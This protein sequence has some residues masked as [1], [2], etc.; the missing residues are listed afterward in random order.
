MQISDFER[1]LRS[2]QKA[3]E[4]DNAIVEKRIAKMYKDAYKSAST[5]LSELYARL[6]DKMSLPEAQKYNRLPLV[7][8]SIAAEYQKL[9]GKNILLAIDTSAQN[10][11]EAFYG[12]QWAAN[13]AIGIDLTWGVL[14]VE[15]IRASV[16]SE[17]SGLTL[18]KTFKKNAA[19]E[20]SSIQAAIT[21]GIATGL[22]YAKTAE[23]MKG[24]FN[25]GFSDAI[26][27]LLT[28]AGRNYTE[29]HLKAHDEALELGIDVVKVWDAT[30]DGRTRDAHGAL[31]CQEED[32]QGNFRSS[33]GG[34]GPG[35]GLMNNAADDIN[36]R[37]RI[38]DN[39]RGMSPELRR[40]RG[41]GV[42]PYKTFKQ[43]SEP[44]GW[45]QT[46]GWPRARWL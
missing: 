1:L 45:T 7:L 31:D 34:Y 9:T 38:T 2:R 28:E 44:K 36:E 24:A 22:G 4:A 5:Q 11:T 15:A 35:P 40:I 17:Y 39:I 10:Y 21:R 25:K 37:C 6:G 8:K 19:Q 18:I 46:R 29:G 13:Q 42:V 32:N 26:R 33:A 41:E 43:W 23:Q 27:V 14:P 30:L 20:L 3:V 12:Y 16:F